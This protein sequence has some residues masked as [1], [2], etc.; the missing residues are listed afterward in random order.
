MYFEYGIEEIESLKGCN[1]LLGAAIAG[2]VI[3]E[4]RDYAPKR[5]KEVSYVS[6]L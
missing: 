5:K 3:L 2:G 4:M 6:I 1:K